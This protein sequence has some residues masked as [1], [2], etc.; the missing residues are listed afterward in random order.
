MASI[1]NKTLCLNV[2]KFINLNYI[3]LQNKKAIVG[4]A[5]YVCNT[6]FQYYSSQA[7]KKHENN[8]NKFNKPMPETPDEKSR[9]L[10]TLMQFPEIVWPSFL[11]SIKNWIMIN[12]VIRP[13][14]DREFELADFITG[15][16]QALQVVS[17]ALSDGDFNSLEDIVDPSA[18]AELKTVLAQMSLSQ[19]SELR[20]AKEDI[21]FTFPYQVGVM[22][23]ESNEKIQKRWVEITMIF[24]V[25]RGLKDFQEKL[26]STKFIIRFIKEFTQGVESSW[27][28]NV[29]NHFK[30][31]DSMSK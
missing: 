14:F 23:D 28:V 19:R 3:T 25:F 17:N 9:K 21:Y 26:G 24:H 27:V 6:N 13:Y 30:P 16:Q 7:P 10:P 18:V 5:A 29:V 11:K 22:F 4:P 31:E 20:V 15:T 1:L 12:F 8:A 2:K